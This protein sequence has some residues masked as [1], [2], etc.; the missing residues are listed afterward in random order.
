MGCT[1]FARVPKSFI[2]VFVGFHQE[3][4]GAP[5]KGTFVIRI[6]LGATFVVQQYTCVGAIKGWSQNPILIGAV[7][8]R[9]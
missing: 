7:C 1:Y 5:L 6:G 2:R 8:S 9:A 4:T 3:P